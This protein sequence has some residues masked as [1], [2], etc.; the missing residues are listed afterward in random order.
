[1]A[2]NKRLKEAM[3]KKANAKAMKGDNDK[4]LTGAGERVRGWISSEL[5]VVVS[6]KEALKSKEQLIKD[7]KDL[8]LELQKL[9]QSTRK[10]MSLEEQKESMKKITE[11]QQDLDLRNAQ[12]SDLQQ[13]ILSFNEEKEKDKADRWARLSSM[14]E[15]KIAA[16]Y[17]F[18][19]ASEMTASSTLFAS[20][21]RELRSQLEDMIST[22]DE[23]K[24]QMHDLK[25]NHEDAVVRMERDHE[26]K[27]LFLL[28][29]LTGTDEPKETESPNV[30]LSKDITTLEERLRFQAQEIERMSTIHDQLME[31][32]KEVCELKDELTSIS[33]GEKGKSLLPNIN[34]G[35]PPQKNTK[36]RVTIAVE[37]YKE[38]ELDEWFSSEE[39]S[40]DE[41]SDE[42]WRKTPMFKRIRKE[43]RSLAVPESRKK[44]R[45][46]A[47]TGEGEV[48]DLENDSYN[49]KKRV[50]AGGCSCKSGC[51]NKRCSCKKDGPYC[52][53]LCKCIASKCANR[54]IPG[55]DVSDASCMSTTDVENS[56]AEN[57]ADT[58][59]KLLDA[60]FELPPVSKF[61]TPSRSP[62]KPVNRDSADMFATVDSDIDAT[63]TNK[64]N[65]AEPHS[66]FFASPQLK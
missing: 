59:A 16:Q 25:M 63:P 28:C 40:E 38:D 23:L 31:K 14:V 5:E 8:N 45:S 11:L 32:E 49:K 10:T 64:P 21:I 36:K 19:T 61:S 52:S 41:E 51:K 58:T 1:V 47:F 44:R 9:K 56:E 26:E 27:I 53:S 7:R 42:E 13:Q 50:S 12:I 17:L 6:A 37:R 18:D 55:A 65:P 39:S 29:Q 24:K 34:V 4:T 54:E 66:S 48:P 62:L 33:R 46:S 22:R 3:E 35:T 57:S 30:T 43:R 15:A 60:T 20:E 2:V